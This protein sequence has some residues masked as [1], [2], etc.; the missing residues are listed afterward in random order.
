MKTTFK[1][2]K[3]IDKDGWICNITPTFIIGWENYGYLK[4]IQI[5]FSFLVWE[6]LIE[7]E[8]K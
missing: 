2:T 1:K 8:F 6:L 3:N 4:V 7:V 5:V